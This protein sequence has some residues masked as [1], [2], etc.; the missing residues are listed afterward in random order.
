MARTR[1]HV[2]TLHRTRRVSG[3]MLLINARPLAHAVLVIY[4]ALSVPM[5]ICFKYEKFVLV[6]VLDVFIDVFF[7]FDLILKCVAV[8]SPPRLCVCAM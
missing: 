2:R 8:A 4:S 1:A 5:D 3:R 6:E 7:I